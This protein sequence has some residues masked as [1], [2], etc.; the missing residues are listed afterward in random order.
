[1]LTHS[2]IFSPFR[3]RGSRIGADPRLTGAST[4]LK[5]DNKLESAGFTLI[6]LNKNPIDI[7]WDGEGSQGGRPGKN[8]EPL[9]ILPVKFAGALSIHFMSLCIYG[10]H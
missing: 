9:Q 4:W 3:T 2:L 6:P 7:V 1:M 5:W 10:L 8:R